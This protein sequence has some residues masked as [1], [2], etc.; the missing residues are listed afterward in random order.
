MRQWRRGKDVEFGKP[1][2]GLAAIK[3]APFYA[4]PVGKLI[5]VTFGGLRTNTNAE[6]LDPQGKPIQRLY[7]VGRVTGGYMQ[8]VSDRR[9]HVR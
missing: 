9:C 3:Q 7:G 5:V 8:V 1:T 4:T 2:R 6:I